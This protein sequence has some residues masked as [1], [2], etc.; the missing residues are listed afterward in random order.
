MAS[1]TSSAGKT[2][3]K[4]SAPLMLRHEA[5]SKLLAFS[6][7]DGLFRAASNETT[8]ARFK[9]VYVS[10]ELVASLR[11]QAREFER[12]SLKVGLGGMQVMT[13]SHCP[14]SGFSN[15]HGFGR[16]CHAWETPMQDPWCY[17]NETCGGI[18]PGAARAVRASAQRGSFGQ[19]FEVCT[20]NPPPASP[21]S[22]PPPPFSPSP[23]PPPPPPAIAPGT[24]FVA[25]AG[26]RC[27]GFSNS[28]GFGAF[29]K[30][31]EAHLPGGEGQKPWCYVD[32]ACEK[33]RVSTKRKRGSF[34][35]SYADCDMVTPENLAAMVTGEAARMVDTTVAQA[36][37]SMSKSG[38]ISRFFGRQLAEAVSARDPAA[39]SAASAPSS[40][41]P[42]QPSKP[43]RPHRAAS[44][45]AASRKRLP[46]RPKKALTIELD[47]SGEQLMAR[48]QRFRPRYVALLHEATSAYLTVERPPHGAAL[49]VHALN[50]QLSIGS[51]FAMIRPPKSVT[52]G[53]RRGR[54]GPTRAPSNSPGYSKLGGSRRARGKGYPAV[55][56]YDAYLISLGV[57]SYLTLCPSHPAGDT[58]AQQGTGP[59]VGTADTL[60]G[61]TLCAGFRPEKKWGEPLRL[62][63]RPSVAA[64]PGAVF[65][66]L[67][68]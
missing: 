47:T 6:P 32:D 30:A 35:K 66:F 51:I 65:S 29:C 17:V 49:Q 3:G 55:Q 8:P 22:P 52:G 68:D 7:A 42:P 67:A 9:M 12:A 53:S 1:L 25:P 18:R 21:P 14:C 4:P 34:G 33:G 48:L 23:S 44:A 59:A 38:L 24:T 19:R 43:S 2:L 61:A 56:P 27:S 57:S 16:Y 15:E 54:L 58:G 40:A 26:C 11:Q 28:H 62:L 63:R 64:A 31:W 13:R 10:H 36:S 60:E 5:S 39:A 41:V 50:P 45:S 46:P 37:K 20:P